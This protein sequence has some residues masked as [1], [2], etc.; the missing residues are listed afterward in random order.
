MVSPESV[1]KKT[2]RTELERLVSNF[3]ANEDELTA[4]GYTEMQARTQFIT[5]FFRALG[6]DVENRA[7][8][9]YREMD[10]L[11][12]RGPEEMKGKPDYTFRIG[13]S[14]KFFVEAKAPHE[15]LE[16]E[17]HVLQAKRYAWST[18][19]VFAVVLT[20]F[21]EFR[22]YDASLKPDPNQPHRGQLLDLLY[23]QYLDR[24]DDLW[25]FS[26]ERVAGG[27][28]EARLPR[29]KRAIRWREPVDDNFLEDM[30][31]W[32]TE[33]A[34][35]V[36]KRNLDLDAHALTDIVQRLLDRFIFIR[37]AEDRRI[38]EKNTL[39]D[40]A[41]D[42]EAMGGR[43]PLLPMVNDLF[44]Q[45][46]DDF[47]GDIFKYH[48]CEEIKLTDQALH[49]I[50]KELYP[51]KSPYR[52]D[53]IP[54][55]IFGAIYE[56]YLG[57]TIHVRGKDVKV[58][59]K[60]EVRKAGGVYYTPKYIVDY[61]VKNTVGK[62]IEGKTPKQIE[63]IKILDPACGSGSF[64]LGAFQCLIDYH[65]AWYEKHP[66]EARRHPMFP[67]L[68]KNGNGEP[69]L[70]LNRKA[71]ILS[72]NLFGVDLDPQA[73]EITMMNLY[74]KAL[75]GEREI[76]H[77]KRVLP[78]LNHNIRCGNSL[79]APDITKEQKLSPEEWERLRPF[80]WNAKFPHIMTAGGFHAVI[81]N[82]PYIFT[83]ETIGVK[84]R[85]Y[86]SDKFALGWEKQNTFMLFME[87]LL[88][89]IRPSG[90][91]S[92]I[93]PNS[94]LTI[95]SAK[96]L[97]Q[98]YL[99]HLRMVLDLNYRVFEGVSMEPSTFV[100]G[101][102]ETATPIGLARI[103]SPT[104]LRSAEYFYADR[105]RLQKH[106][107]IVFHESNSVSDL[108]ERILTTTK[109][110]G[111]LFVVRTGLQAYEK[112]KGKPPQ[113]AED[114]RKHVFDRNRREN[115]YSIRYLEGR[116]VERYGIH[117]SGLWMQYGPWL[118]Q[119]RE[120]GI[121][122][123]P[124][125]LLREITA[126]P[127]YF[128]HYAYVEDQFLNNKSVLNI[129]D[130]DDNPERLKA[131]I[132]VLNSKLISFFYKKQAV[133]SGRK[134]F[135]KVVARDLARFPVPKNLVTKRFPELVQSVEAMLEAK[136]HLVSE[137]PHTDKAYYREKC[138]ALDRQIDQLV[139]DLYGL[140]PEEIALV[141]ESFAPPHNSGA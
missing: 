8:K 76:P 32:R 7:A 42:W 87:R 116:D 77:N 134:I 90:L 95:E 126:Q 124:R 79:I 35:A 19:E 97:R 106:N 85:K 109:P 52:F 31:R 128:L 82:P 120:I 117:W 98:R 47:N 61:I 14:A 15:D 43:K 33:L 113:S 49:R 83:R 73:V 23:T 69:R 26:R 63:K 9:S 71:K 129:L 136:K 64:L 84:E 114:V 132:G 24:I 125:I 54:V 10:V 16:N 4:P 65:V 80:D 37:V 96:L 133:K 17:R 138:A 78:E 44:H 123:R 135:P 20:D 93:V 100:V 99:L 111:E 39:L 88:Q 57:K 46:N 137:E 139:F 51:P 6:W 53:V 29:D 108:V 30:T 75:E 1:T 119:P 11:E 127:P 48:R 118:A 60:P 28:L 103:K 5:P 25:D 68:V 41:L 34:K 74:L 22:F 115:K 141:E 36:H 130:H 140:T 105:P 56:R 102:K 101:G 58:E 86:Y 67:E 45:I 27:A 12:E 112:S 70:S 91:G 110:L 55:D 107:R 92:F 2:F 13:G 59:D 18:K 66:K 40:R 131:L 89:L 121:F 94:W 3:A 21:E 104:E 122:M 62:V 72:H 38:V 50:I 81:G